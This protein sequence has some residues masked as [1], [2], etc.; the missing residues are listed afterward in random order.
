MIEPIKP[1]EKTPF[2]TAVF[3]VPQGQSGQ[4]YRM[5]QNMIPV[6]KRTEVYQHAMTEQRRVLQGLQRYKYATMID[7]KAGYFNVPFD[8]DSSY[9]TTFVTHRGK[10]RWKR[11]FFG[12]TQAPA[13][14][15][16]VV[17]DVIQGGGQDQLPCRIYIDD[18]VLFG[19]D[20][21]QLLDNSIKAIQRLA[22]AGFM[23]NLRKS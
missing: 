12:L 7:L 16:A 3:L 8:E 17:E 14:F 15:Q 11:L 9:L 10:F 22:A 6:N 4:P 23:V 1:H 19:D 13:H 20:L 2:T 21:D 18:I 5:V